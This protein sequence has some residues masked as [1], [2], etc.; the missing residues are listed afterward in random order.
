MKKIVICHSCQSINKTDLELAKTKAPVCGKCQ[1]P[2]DISPN[3]QT[4]DQE[5]INKIIRHAELPVFIDI[6][7]DWCGPCQM[8]GP[9]FSEFAK[10]NWN[11]AEYFKLDSEKNAQFCINHSIRGIPATIIYF[12][13]K[14][15]KNQSGLL[16]KNVLAS[17][18][19]EVSALNN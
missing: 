9:I 10:E 13:G 8:Y 15:I 2:L 7:A 17:L 1:S 11:K 5:K 3:V 6:F 14:L 4:L 12:Q 16:Q 19:S 18:L